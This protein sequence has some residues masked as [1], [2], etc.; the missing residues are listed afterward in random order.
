MHTKHNHQRQQVFKCSE[1]EAEFKYNGHLKRHKTSKHKIDED[2]H[3]YPGDEQAIEFSCNTCHKE[4]G[5]KDLLMKHLATHQLKEKL[6][7]LHCG[8]LFGRKDNLKVHI[9]FQHAYPEICYSC[10]LCGKKFQ[11]KSNLKR[12]M[13]SLHNM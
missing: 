4:F 10:K 7:C 1:C 13:L 6:S 5:R 2:K 9:K 11:R 3:M 8:K 12:H